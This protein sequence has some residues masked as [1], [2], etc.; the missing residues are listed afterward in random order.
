MKTLSHPAGMLVFPSGSYLEEVR[1]VVHCASG[2]EGIE[3]ALLP[4]DQR[5]RWCTA[6]YQL[7]VRFREGTTSYL[8]MGSRDS[9][10]E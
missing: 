6:P 1:Q 10:G 3:R 7:G 8:T 4:G 2:D 5:Q 9:A